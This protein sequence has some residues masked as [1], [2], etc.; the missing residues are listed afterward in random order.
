MN[1]NI[2]QSAKHKFCSK[3]NNKIMYNR[4]FCFLLD[5]FTGGKVCLSCVG[6]ISQ[7]TT[8]ENPF[9]SL[10]MWDPGIKLRLSGFI[11]IL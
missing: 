11:A 5:L 1:K 6:V 9:S 3:G 10:T 4:V 7:R 8:F 2:F